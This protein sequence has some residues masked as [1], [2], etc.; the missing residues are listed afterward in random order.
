[1][2]NDYIILGI[3]ILIG[4]LYF[5]VYEHKYY[6]CSLFLCIYTLIFV[7]YISYNLKKKKNKLNLDKI[8]F[9]FINIF[10]V[11]HIYHLFYN[12][13]NILLMN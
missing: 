8:I 9:L 2:D 5:Y 1:M 13:N 4:S 11:F 6:N 12:Y 7:I 3:S 10:L